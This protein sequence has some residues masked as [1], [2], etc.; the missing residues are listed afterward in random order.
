MKRL[1]EEKRRE[2]KGKKHTDKNKRREYEREI[3][4]EIRVT[5]REGEKETGKYR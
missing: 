1:R 4:E 2:W 5:R 3:K